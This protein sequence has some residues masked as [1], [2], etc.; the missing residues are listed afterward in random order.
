MAKG[1]GKTLDEALKD[2]AGKVPNPGDGTWV[3]VSV[4]AVKTT[5][6]GDRISD[7]RVETSP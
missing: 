4:I 3:K 5:P 1:E 7:Y 2:A 6:G